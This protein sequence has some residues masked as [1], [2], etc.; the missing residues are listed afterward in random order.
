MT[1]Q[2]S[3]KAKAGRI[4]KAIRIKGKLKGEEDLVVE[5]KV[6]GTLSFKNN[7]VTLERSAVIKAD[8]DVKEITIKGDMTGNTVASERVALTQAA[9]V[10]GD[11][12]APRL[13]VEEGAKFRG[14]VIMDVPLPPGLLDEATT[15]ASSLR[16][17]VAQYSGSSSPSKHPPRPADRRERSSQAP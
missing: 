14:A 13:V 9:K 7:H 15:S 4:G 16:D 2:A 10:A 6:E 5:G 17:A 8:V 1:A 12:R 3:E 11:I